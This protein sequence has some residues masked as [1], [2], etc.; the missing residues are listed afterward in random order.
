MKM[1]CRQCICTHVSLSGNMDELRAAID[2]GDDAAM[3]RIIGARHSPSVAYAMKRLPN[4]PHRWRWQLTEQLTAA[5]QTGDEAW[6]KEYMDAALAARDMDAVRVVLSNPARIQSMLAV[7]VPLTPD[8]AELLGKLATLISRGDWAGVATVL[9]LDMRVEIAAAALRLLQSPDLPN[10][11]AISVAIMTARVVDTEMALGNWERVYEML[12]QAMRSDMIDA[13]LAILGRAIAGRWTGVREAAVHHLTAHLRA[14]FDLELLVDAHAVMAAAV[15]SRDE[16][17]ARE[18]ASIFVRIIRKSDDTARIV[19][20]VTCL[21][22]HLAVGVAR[23]PEQC[24]SLIID[25]W[26]SL[27]QV[28]TDNS[29]KTSVGTAVTN[30]LLMNN[31]PWTVRDGAVGAISVLTKFLLIAASV[32]PQRHAARAVHVIRTVA[33]VPSATKF[34]GVYAATMKKKA[35][36]AIVA[37]YDREIK[38]LRGGDALHLV[39]PLVC[40]DGSVRLGQAFQYLHQA[41]KCCPAILFRSRVLNFAR[42]VA[43]YATDTYAEEL[44]EALA[45]VGASLAEAMEGDVVDGPF[46]GAY[47]CRA[48][49]AETHNS[50]GFCGKVYYCNDD[51]ERK[52]RANHKPGCLCA[53]PG[54]FCVAGFLCGQ[55]SRRA[56]CSRA[57]QQTDRANHAL[58]CTIR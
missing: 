11:V 8:E 27:P 58:T 53:A 50:C 2:A 23:W 32:D 31:A 13:A 22:R 41:R 9:R 15:A 5:A 54:C 57:C 17:V 42:V 3:E 26:E 4:L 33:R 45:L 6:L 51:C 10:D 28:H 46:L 55:C 52:D 25:M 30:N 35:L 18:V 12:D 14:S 7:S 19:P 16:P 20:F 47:M 36:D 21:M 1:T 37:F 29:V 24:V 34:E 56:Y 44:A 43:P 39:L 38:L 40:A 48:C 49:G